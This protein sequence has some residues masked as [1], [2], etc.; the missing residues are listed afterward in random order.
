MKTAIFIGILLCVNF[1]VLA[2]SSPASKSLFDRIWDYI[3]AGLSEKDWDESTYINSNLYKD[4]EFRFSAAGYWKF[5]IGDNMQWKEPAYEDNKWT[6]IRVP[7][8]WENEGFHGYDG[9]AWYRYHFDGRKL[10]AEDINFLL[11]GFI[12]DVD[13]TYLNGQLVG[14]SG[15]LPPRFR[16]AYNA[17]RKY[18]LPNEAV[19]FKGEN[20]LAVRVYDEVANGGIVD[21]NIGFYSSKNSSG[22]YL[23]QNLQGVWKFTTSDKPYFYN[24]DLDD[25]NWENVLAPA[26]WDNFGYRGLDGIAWYRKYFS[27]S[28][29]PQSDKTYYLL[30]GKIDDFDETYLNGKKIG[31]TKDF[32]PL[33]QSNSYREV[34]IYEIPAGLLD[35]GGTNLVAVRVT[36]IGVEGGIYEGPLGIVEAADLA[37]VIRAVNR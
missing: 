23:L 6:Q 36:D 29:K 35:D 22:S 19:N 13:E 18:L 31:F 21:G 2:Q 32:R 14:K 7:A 34:R 15:L 12:D 9:Y 1:T 24:T 26:F 16:T 33:G 20:V 28:F 37:A 8:D 4:L 17:V 25:R 27:L 30:M 5:N 11:L 3:E 10:N